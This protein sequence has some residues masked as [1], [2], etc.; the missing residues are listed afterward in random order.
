[1][2][3]KLQDLR[4]LHLAC[5]IE[6]AFEGLERGLEKHLP[7]HVRKELE[8]LFQEGPN[9]H[10]LQQA[11]AEVNHESAEHESDVTA[12]QLVMAIRDCEALAREFYHNNARK[13]S[14]PKLQKI[15]LGMAAEEGAH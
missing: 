2:Q 4:Y 10:R 9:H 7:P 6:E 12:R 14:D 15:F 3:A 8:A 5:Q 11:F 1:M 13:L